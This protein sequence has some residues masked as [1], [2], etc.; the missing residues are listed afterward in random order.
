MAKLAEL[1]KRLN[2]DDF[3]MPAM[4]MDT[5]EDRKATFESLK[6]RF[7]GTAH[8]VPDLEA[9]RVK[10]DELKEKLT[11]LRTAQSTDEKP[12]KSF[13]AEARKM[14]EDSL[15]VD[16]VEN[17]AGKEHVPKAPRVGKDGKPIVFKKLVGDSAAT[18]PEK[19]TDIMNGPGKRNIID[20]FAAEVQRVQEDIVRVHNGIFFYT[21]LSRTIQVNLVY[22]VMSDFMFQ[23]GSTTETLWLLQERTQAYIDG[24]GG[25]DTSETSEGTSEFSCLDDLEEAF[26]EKSEE[27]ETALQQC[28]R[29]AYNDAYNYI[30]IVYYP[31]IDRTMVDLSALKYIILENMSSAN[32]AIHQQMLIDYLDTEVEN[33][34]VY[35]RQQRE[36][37]LE[38]EQFRYADEMREVFIS[39]NTCL[40][41]VEQDYEEELELLRDIYENCDY[42]RSI[43]PQGEVFNTGG[44]VA[45]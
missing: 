30:R 8:Q 34:E 2:I 27:A 20:D 41:D 35:E 6:S 4:K 18:R 45:V 3:A 1:K 33:G 11:K 24:I 7:A 22:D 12:G 5:A 25:G 17:P 42:S 40:A 21:R 13:L 28:A 32:M 9:R 10:L 29:T 36:V 37:A 31:M 26:H 43:N 16:M 14:L 38:W 44:E 15:K 39:M 19:R 23:L